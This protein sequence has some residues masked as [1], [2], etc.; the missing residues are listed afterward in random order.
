L[1]YKKILP[2]RG[3]APPKA[4]A[5]GSLTMPHAPAYLQAEKIIKESK[6]SGKI[7]RVAIT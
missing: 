3:D 2:F 7:L 5:E 4:G 1:Q 6:L